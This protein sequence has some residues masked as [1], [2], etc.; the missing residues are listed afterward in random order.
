MLEIVVILGVISIL[1][2]L[3]IP[4]VL[5]IGKDADIS[6]AQ[7]LLNNA[8]ADCLQSYRNGKDLSDTIPNEEI[9]SDERLSA[10]NYRIKRSESLVNDVIIYN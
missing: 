4:N 7:A 3:T 1:S 6:E 2:S 9:I 8:A 5:R 10:I